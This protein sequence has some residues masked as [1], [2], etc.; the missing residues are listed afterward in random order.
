MNM[1]GMSMGSPTEAHS[2]PQLMPAWLEIA[3]VVVFLLIAACH[4]RHVVRSTGDR[5]AWHCCHVAMAVGMASMY[6]PA[7][8][9]PS[10]VPIEWW[11]VLSFSAVLAIGMRCLSVYAGVAR[12]NPL[13]ML[14]GI[15]CAAML[16]MWASG[17]PLPFIGWAFVLCLFAEASFWAFGAYRLVDRPETGTVAVNAS[18]TAMALGMAY[19]LAASQLM[20]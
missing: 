10:I 6:A 20:T 2:V 8:I 9:I 4:L 12:H 5:C 13:W 1:D 11:Q 7:A 18:M 14:A 17:S 16:Y 3:F 19:M 15:D